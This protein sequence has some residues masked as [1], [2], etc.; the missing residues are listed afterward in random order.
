MRRPALV[1][2]ILVG[3]VA[4]LD[5][6]EN[7]AR[8]RVTYAFLGQDRSRWAKLATLF[9]GNDRGSLFRP[10]PGDEVLLAF[11]MGDPDR[12]YVLGGLWNLSDRPPAM[13]EP[14]KENNWR[15]LRSRSGHVLKFDDKNG[16]ERIEIRDK[17]DQRTIVIDT[18]GRR[19]EIDCGGENGEV[20]V[21]AS[22]GTVTIAA[23]RKIA[24]D[25]AAGDVTVSARGGGA[26]R[27]DSESGDVSVN[28]ETGLVKVQATR[29]ALDAGADMSLK[30]GTSMTLEAAGT[31]NLKGLMVNIN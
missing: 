19:I 8:V 13:G 24:V 31:L 6:P 21:R 15:L 5:D 12:P 11:E 28:A 25:C 2:G 4:D 16:A 9:A 26:V 17:E 3:I 1:N 22:E 30:A 7:L 23:Q 18:P 14:A 10:E 29:I 27:V 20:A